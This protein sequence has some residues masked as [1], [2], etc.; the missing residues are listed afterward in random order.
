M[1][2]SS[3]FLNFFLALKTNWFIKSSRPKGGPRITTESTKDRE[4][5]GDELGME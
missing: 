4:S 3:F 2:G 1:I 5:A